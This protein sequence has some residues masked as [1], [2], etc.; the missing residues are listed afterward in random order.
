[1]PGFTVLH[2][3]PE[4]AQ[5]PKI[6]SV[7]PSN[8]LILCHTL[9][10]L[11]SIFPRIRVFSIELA[12]HIRWPKY[13]NF[14]ISPCNEYSGLISFRLTG[15]ISLLSKELSRVFSSTTVQKHQFFGTQPSLWS[16][17]HIHTQQLENPQ[18]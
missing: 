1:M 18:F 14:S 2:Y 13:W 17:S 5:T 4:F 12:L 15:L 16:N 8:H 6:E 7:M 11:L 10:L 9:I 3:L